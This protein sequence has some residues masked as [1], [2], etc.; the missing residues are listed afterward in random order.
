MIKLKCGTMCFPKRGKA[1]EPVE[2]YEQTVNKFVHV[3]T[4]YPCEARITETP[5]CKGCNAEVDKL[6]CKDKKETK[7]YLKNEFKQITRLECMECPKNTVSPKSTTEE[8]ESSSPVAGVEETP[9]P[10]L[11]HEATESSI[12]TLDS[13]D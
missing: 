4:I 2:G 7:A 11:I 5:S 13:I 8:K 9:L 1:P 12:P 6:F 3:P 10:A